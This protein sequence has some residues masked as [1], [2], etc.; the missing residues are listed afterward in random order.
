[1]RVLGLDHGEKRIGLA[2]SDFMRIIAQP[3]FTIVRRDEQDLWLQ[4]EAVI[5]EN[6]VATVVV[7][8]PV[9][10]SGKPSTQT[11]VV[12]QFIEQFKDR[13]AVDLETYDERLSSWAAK[14]SMQLQGIKTGH[15]KATIDMT[16]AA[17]FLQ[18]YLDSQSV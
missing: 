1:M 9:S 12:D 14:Q 18:D 2:L 6:E 8:Y 3:L 17:I 5:A 7:G 11:Q 15:N 13:F 10:M 16:A 4:L